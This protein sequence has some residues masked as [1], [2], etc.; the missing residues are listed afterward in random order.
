MVHVYI[1][2]LTFNRVMWCTVYLDDE[3][4]VY[5]VLCVFFFSLCMS[6]H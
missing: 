6:E 2:A 3:V 5:V 1:V 4:V